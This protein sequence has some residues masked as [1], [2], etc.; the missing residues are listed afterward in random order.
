MKMAVFKITHKIFYII[1]FGI[2]RNSDLG[3]YL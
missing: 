1:V 2:V 3:A